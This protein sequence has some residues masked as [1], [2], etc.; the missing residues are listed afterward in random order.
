VRRLLYEDV[1]AI[2]EK[3]PKLE[4]LKV[5]HNGFVALPNYIRR[6]LHLKNLDVSF[7]RNLT[8]IPEL[9]SSV[10]K[11]DAR[12]CQSLTPETLSFLWSKVLLLSVLFT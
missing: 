3:F 5:S 6:S 1:N 8:E 7:C 4:D 11:I 10:Q 9:P 2:I 12:H